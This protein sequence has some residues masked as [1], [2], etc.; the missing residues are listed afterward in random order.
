MA[1]PTTIFRA[2]SPLVD[3]I[4]ATPKQIGL[5]D[6]D[7][8]SVKIST[9]TGE[10]LNDVTVFGLHGVVVKTQY[11]R[12]LDMSIID[13]FGILVVKVGIDAAFPGIPIPP[14]ASYCDGAKQQVTEDE[15]MRYA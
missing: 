2:I 1:R 6:V 10:I 4:D 14:T 11:G 9:G 13:A 7:R 12:S 15:D 3:I 5:V 8:S